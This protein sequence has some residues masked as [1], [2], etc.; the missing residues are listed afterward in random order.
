MLLRTHPQ[1]P[2]TSPDGTSPAPPPWTCLPSILL[3]HQT[4]HRPAPHQ[5][6]HLQHP[7]TDNQPHPGKHV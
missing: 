6:H 2:I 1:A 4:V 5:Y 3:L 7:S